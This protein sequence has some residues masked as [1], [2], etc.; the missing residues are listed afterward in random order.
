MTIV[1]LIALLVVVFASTNIDDIF[2]LVGF[3]SDPRL[4]RWQIVA[5]Q[6]LGIG[7]IVTASL[8]A[9]FVALAISASYVGL[10]GFAPLAIGVKKLW[11]LRRRGAIES[12]PRDRLT[13]PGGMLAVTLVTIANSGDNLGVY[14]PLF[15]TQPLW[16]VLISVA[17]FATMTLAWCLAAWL[18]VSNPTLGKLAR[19]YGHRALPFVLIGLGGFILYTSGAI[20][21]LASLV[22]R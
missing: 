7:L 21:L 12:E 2:V 1:S 5:G 18:L 3:F 17:V 13:G 9:A 22:R 14:A 6:F 8:A 10:L 4:G 11:D 20:D 16:Q 19:L 15:A